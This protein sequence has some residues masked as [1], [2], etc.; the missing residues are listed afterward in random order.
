MDELTKYDQGQKAYGLQDHIVELIV[1]QMYL[2]AS[3]DEVSRTS[4]ASTLSASLAKS[5]I[6]T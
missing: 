3:D 2:P 1:D 6:V 4:T 5:T